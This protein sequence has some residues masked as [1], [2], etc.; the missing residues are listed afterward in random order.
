MKVID[1]RNLV[2][3]LGGSIGGKGNGRGYD[4]FI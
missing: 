3:A 4:W 1:V 2:E